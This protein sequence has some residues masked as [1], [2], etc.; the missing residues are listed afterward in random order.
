MLGVAVKLSATPG[1]VRTPPPRLGE[2]TARVLREDVGVDT[3]T[4]EKL[5]AA[6]IVRMAR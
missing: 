6:G 5:V 1:N 3:A 4:L 2:H